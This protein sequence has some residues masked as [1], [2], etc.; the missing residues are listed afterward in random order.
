M[1]RDLGCDLQLMPWFL[2]IVL[3]SGDGISGEPLGDDSL[4]MME[5]LCEAVSSVSAACSC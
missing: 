1:A 4:A 5:L 3:V 2:L